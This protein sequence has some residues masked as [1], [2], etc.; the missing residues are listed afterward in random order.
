MLF[1]TCSITFCYY[2]CLSVII[3]SDFGRVIIKS[4]ATIFIT[5]KMATWQSFRRDYAKKNPGTPL[6]VVAN[7]WREYKDS[8]TRQTNTILRETDNKV[9]LV[10][11]PDDV[12]Q[13]ILF[14]L[15]EK[16]L[17]KTCLVCRRMYQ[18][19]RKRIKS[20]LT[21]ALPTH[22]EIEAFL[23]DRVVIQNTDLYVFDTEKDRIRSITIH[24]GV[25]TNTITKSNKS[26]DF[27]G[28][29]TTKHLLDP[30]NMLACMFRRK[31]H[32]NNDQESVVLEYVQRIL[33]PI[34]LKT[35]TQTQIDALFAIDSI[36]ARNTDKLCKSV[37]DIV[38]SNI[39]IDEET[40]DELNK[41]IIW[42]E[43]GSLAEYR[44]EKEQTPLQQALQTIVFAYRSILHRAIG[45][46][47]QMK[48]T[49]TLVLEHVR[50]RLRVGKRTRVAFFTVNSYPN[51][52]KDDSKTVVYVLDMENMTTGT[53]TEY[54]NDK[55]VIYSGKKV[56]D[57]MLRT[58]EVPG[59]V[60]QD[61]AKLALKGTIPDIPCKITMSNI[62]STRL[63]RFRIHLC[64]RTTK[65]E[66]K[67]GITESK[68]GVCKDVMLE[69]VM[70]LL[71]CNKDDMLWKLSQDT[72]EKEGMLNITTQAILGLYVEYKRLSVSE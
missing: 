35:I 30:I 34:L 62:V 25:I 70:Y 43:R 44:Y 32:V 52:F 72:T 3:A 13:I 48:V 71:W 68:D 12:I 7:A 21:K 9:S 2:T 17:L 37:C 61:T 47:N 50:E 60:D 18:S 66:I 31:M 15:S 49:T 39:E 54:N 46:F 28:M 58:K 11:L 14:L 69:Y 24:D 19:C 57:R 41:Y 53:F 59:M 20:I 22:R 65:E 56:L 16:D 5:P 29:L 64:I 10:S 40:L 27:D 51:S 38:D 42:I 26:R 6:T 63:Y 23:R 1:V 45:V 55:R 67:T 33:I 36:T 4:I 8:I